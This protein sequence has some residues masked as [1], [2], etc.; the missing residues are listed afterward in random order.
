MDTNPV[1]ANTSFPNASVN[2]QKKQKELILVLVIALLVF[3]VM[4]IVI[5]ATR[6]TSIVP[7]KPTST[8]VSK[9]PTVNLKKEYKNPFDKNAQYV[10]PFSQYKN[11]FDNLK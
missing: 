11:P 5:V 3:V 4:V 10:N 8:G 6:S 7:Q 2:A 1:S 9:E